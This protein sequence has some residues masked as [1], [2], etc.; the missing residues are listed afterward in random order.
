LFLS[1]DSF[2]FIDHSIHQI[3][4]SY[5]E[6][7]KKSVNDFIYLFLDEIT[8][9]D[10]F[11]QELKSFYDSENMKIICS[12]SIAT[13]MRDKRAYLTG[14]TKT[15]EIMHLDF[16]EFLMFKRSGIKKSDNAILESY[17]KDYLKTINRG[18]SSSIRIYKKYC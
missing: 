13:L 10:N 15:I 12:S 4:E 2:N 18:R 3:I 1:L 9:K 5:R 14:R 8:A 11:E 7:H 17:F 6:I 16:N